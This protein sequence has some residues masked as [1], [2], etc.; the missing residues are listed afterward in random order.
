MDFKTPNPHL[1]RVM[2]WKECDSHYAEKKEKTYDANFFK[3]H[4]IF[5]C[6]E[7]SDIIYK[8]VKV[9]NTSLLLSC[10]T[11]LKFSIIIGDRAKNSK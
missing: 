3:S 4:V 7:I 9:Y 1:G 2:L 11:L 10:F 5:L 6:A 8:T